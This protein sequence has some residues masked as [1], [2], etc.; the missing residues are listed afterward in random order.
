MVFVHFLIHYSDEIIGA[1]QDLLMGGGG[2]SEIK[3][4]TSDEIKFLEKG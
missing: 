4:A 1:G 3:K 2:L